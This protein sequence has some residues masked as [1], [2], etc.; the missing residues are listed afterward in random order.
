MKK[1]FMALLLVVVVLSVSLLPACSNGGTTDNGE[2][3]KL[4]Y[5]NF[6]PPTHYNSILA[7]QW[8]QEIEKQTNGKVDITYYAGGQLATAAKTYDGVVQGICDIGMSVFS[9]T[10][11]RFPVCELID[12]PH[13]YPNG[14][15]ATMVANDY[16]NEFKPAE[17]NDVHPLYFHATGP[18]VIFTTKMPVRTMDDLKGLVLRATGIGTQI[19]QSLG[20]QG[21]GATQ[22]ETADLLS[23]GVVEGNYST[24]ESLKAYKQAEVVKYVTN[25]T[26]VGNTSMMFVVMNEAKWNS[27]PASVQKVFTAVSKEFIQKHGKAWNYGDTGGVDYFLGLGGGREVI[28][29]S[30]SETDKWVTAAVKPMIDKYISEK[31]TAGLTPSKYESYINERVEYWSAKTPS[32]ESVKTYMESEVINWKAET[33]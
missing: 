1:R 16:Y 13:S 33:K 14:W 29:L 5:N 12:L 23:K 6:F 22:G 31:T 4:T 9:Y 8:I 20:A 2:V 30:Q 18:Y 28:N 32:A 17:L 15:V 3:I 11:G 19:V 25:C 27:L 10:P 26:A 24:L 7:E 21:Y